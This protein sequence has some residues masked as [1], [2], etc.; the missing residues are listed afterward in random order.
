[1]KLLLKFVTVSFSLSILLTGCSGKSKTTAENSRTPIQSRISISSAES[2]DP[3]TASQ[4]ND[5]DTNAINSSPKDTNTLIHSNTSSSLSQSNS[6]NISPVKKSSFTFPKVMAD[7]MVLQRNATIRIWGSYPKDGEVTVSLAGKN[8]KGKCQNGNFEVMI[9][10]GSAGGPYTM[11]I[12][13]QTDKTTLNDILV[14]DVYLCSGQSNM[15]MQVGALKDK[16][17]RNTPVPDKIRLLHVWTAPSKTPMDDF[18]HPYST[19]VKTDNT[20]IGHYDNFSAVAYI[21]GKT[22]YE[23]YKIPIGI[24]QACEGDTI[25]ASWIPEKDA[26]TVNKLNQYEDSLQRR[27]ASRM[28][29]GMIHPLTKYTFKGVLWYQGE[30]DINNTSY[31]G[32][33]ST[34]IQSWRR[35][36]NNQN[37]TFTIIQLPRWGGSRIGEWFDIRNQQKATALSVPNCTYSVNLDCGEMS[38]IHPQ[39]KEPIGVR[40]AQATMR[41]FYGDSS[42]KSSPTYQSHTVNGNKV[43]ITFSNIDKGLIFRTEKTAGQKDWKTATEGIGFEI[44]DSSGEYHAAKAILNGNTLVLSSDVAIPRGIRYG[45]VGTSNFPD[46]S[47]FDKNGLPAEQF[48]VNLN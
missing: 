15:L 36:F 20:N 40:A 25:A 28:Y 32:T 17:L 1:M 3:M 24:I 12:S 11:T 23:K 13:S 27:I 8:F 41:A 16:T 46:I 38:D 19:W 22:L 9:K 4:Y 6:T 30:S 43:L 14:G 29:N 18:D 2:S 37:M 26:Q 47:L 39:D 5:S 33:M 21:F 34:L 44:K 10:T 35:E 42:Y 7:H 45:Y 31:Q 48:Q